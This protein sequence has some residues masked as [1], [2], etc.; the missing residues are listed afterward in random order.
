[1]NLQQKIDKLI[2]YVSENFITYPLWEEG[3]YIP[4]LNF[5][6]ICNTGYELE[7]LYE[8]MLFF[9][10]NSGYVIWVDDEDIKVGK[11]FELQINPE[12]EELETGGYE[13]VNE[14]WSIEEMIEIVGE[15]IKK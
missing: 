5:W 8:R 15:I 10:N 7:I 6:Q 12:Y 1:M 3:K 11:A 13:Y 2:P 4:H 14:D 9:E